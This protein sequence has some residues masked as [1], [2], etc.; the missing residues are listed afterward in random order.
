LINGLSPIIFASTALAAFKLN[1]SDFANFYVYKTK[2]AQ[3]SPQTP[4]QTQKE[5]RLSSKRV[6]GKL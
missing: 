6:S 1:E 4:P 2:Q 5:K 3:I